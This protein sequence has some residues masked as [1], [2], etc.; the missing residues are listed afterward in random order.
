MGWLDDP[1]VKPTAPAPAGWWEKD[2]LAQAEPRAAEGAVESMQAGLQ[3]SVGGLFW[4][5]KLPDL[6]MD[7]AHAKWWERAL[8]GI[9]QVGADILPMGLGAA[10]GGAAGTAAGTPAGPGGMAVGGVLGAGAGMFGVPALMRE[11]LINGYKSGEINTAADF[12]NALRSGAG[13]IAK[14][15][16]KEALV[17]AA[18]FGAGAVAARTV[19]KALLPAIGESIAVPTAT[20]IIGT[21]DTAAQI[22]TMVTMPAALQGR[23]PDAI[24]FMDAAIVIGGLKAAHP[25]AA[26]ITNVFQRTGRTPAQQ[27]ADAQADPKI[28]EELR[29]GPAADVEVPPLRGQLS[30]Q[31]ELWSIQDRIG[32]I[33]AA[34]DDRPEVRV[35]Y[36]ALK[37]KATALEAEG[38]K[39]EVPRGSL[40]SFAPEQLVEAKDRAAQRIA[41]LTTKEGTGPLTD[42]ERAERIGLVNALNNPEALAKRFGMEPAIKAITDA[43]RQASAER[44]AEEVRRQAKEADMARAVPLGDEHV[45]AITQLVLAR[46]KTR[47]ARLGILPEELYAERPLRIR[48]EA[49]AEIEAE[50]AAIPPEAPRFTPPEV[51]LFGNPIA[52]E[53]APR[54]A[55]A[56][57]A[58]VEV[59]LAGLKLSKEVPQFKKD[60]NAEGVI[61]PLG[62]KFDRTGVGPIQVWERI[63]GSMEVISGRHRLDLARRSGEETIPAQIHREADGFTAKQAA[64][65][66]AQLNIR[67][68]QG[69]G[70][71]FAQYFRDSGISEQTANELGLLARA[72]GRGGFAI[73]RDASPDLLAA[74]RAGLLSDDAALAISSTAPGSARLQ[75]LGIAM[76]NDGKSALYAANM[77]RSI[78]LMAAERMA[79]GAQGDIFGFDDSAM[80][81]A[82]AMAKKASSK[83]R[84]ISEQISA[85]SGASRRPELARKMGVD[86]QDPEGIQKKIAELKQEQYQ[87]DNWPLY[88]ELVAK[89][90]AS[91]TG[92]AKEPQADYTVD[93][94][95]RQ[96]TGRI[97]AGGTE[98]PEGQFDLFAPAPIPNSPVK[99]LE[100]IVVEPEQVGKQAVSF[101]RVRDA[102]EA[103]SI[104]QDLNR[105]PMEKFQVL[106]L[107]EKNKPIAFFDLFAGTVNQTSV[108]PREVWTAIYQTPG[109][110]SVWIAHQHPSGL[111]EPSNADRML[112]KSLRA[113]LTPDIGVTL[114]GHLIITN[115]KTI[116]IG[117]G[118]DEL[119]A[120]TLKAGTSKK[121]IPIMERK[122]VKADDV[123]ES[124]SSPAAV[125]GFLKS[126]SPDDT[127]LLVLDSQ[128]RATGWWPM[129]PAEMATLRTG[130][131]NT[132]MGALIRNVGRGNANSVIAYSPKPTTPEFEKGVRNAGTALKLADV[133]MLDAFTL[134]EQRVLRSHAEAGLPMT[135]L[136]GTFFQSAPRDIFELKPETPAELKA[137][138]EE[139][140]KAAKRKLAQ[141]RAGVKGPVPTVD[142]ADLFNTQRTLFQTAPPVNSEPFKRW[143]GG[144]K[145]TDKDGKPLLVYTGQP[146]DPGPIFLS[147]YK[148]PRLAN[149]P[150][151]SD[152]GF[153]FADQ[154]DVAAAYS[155]TDDS[156]I[157]VVK[158]LYLS[159]QHPLDLRNVG[160]V[161]KLRKSTLEPLQQQLSEFDRVKYSE[162]RKRISRVTGLV[163]PAITSEDLRT[164]FNQP[165]LA[166]EFQ[167]TLDE[168]SAIVTQVEDARGDVKG[169]RRGNYLEQFTPEEFQRILNANGVEF[170]I[171][172]YLEEIKENY[173]SALSGRPTE[174]MP[175]YAFWDFVQSHRLREA[176]KRSGY[177]GII[178][179]EEN[180]ALK[181]K[182]KDVPERADFYPLKGTSYVAFR[183]EQIK[184]A[185]GNRGTF[186]PN[187]PNI[188][189]QSKEDKP[190]Y[191]SELARSVEASPMKQG[192]AKA[193][194]DYIKSRVGK[195]V[196]NEEIDATGINDWLATQEGKVTK[197]QVQAFMEQ[198]GVKVTETMLG[199]SHNPYDA[200]VTKMEEKYGEGYD[201]QALT[202]A[203]R[204][205]QGR[206]WDLTQQRGG[207]TENHTKFQ[208]YQEP[209][210]VPGSYR[211]LVLTLPPVA[212]KAF[213]PNKVTVK[214]N[215]ISTTQG[216]AEIYYDGQKL[217]GPYSDNTGTPSNN[218]MQPESYWIDSARKIWEKGITTP[219]GRQQVAAKSG[220]FSSSH[221]PNAGNYLAH[222]RVND[223]ILP[224]GRKVLFV[225]EIQSDRAQKGRTDGFNSLTPAQVERWKELD[226]MASQE[227]E[228]T[229]TEQAEYDSLDARYGGHGKGGVPAAPFVTKTDSWT[230]L[231][232]KRLLRYAA[233]GEYDAIAWT[234]GEQQVERYTSA[235][236]K[237]V[238]TIEWKKTPEGVQIVGYKNAEKPVRTSR[239]DT[240]AE[241]WAAAHRHESEGRTKVVDTT[242]KESALSDAIGKSMA[243]R[244]R[245]DPNQT[246]TIEGENITVND[247]GMAESY[248]DATGRKGDGTPA[249]ITKV[250]NQILKRMEGGKVSEIKIEMPAQEHD[251]DSIVR[252]VNGRDIADQGQPGFEITPAMREKIMAGQAL[253]QNKGQDRG[254]QHLGSYSIAENLITT[255]RNANKSTV[256]HE[257]SHS[258]LEEMKADAARPDAPAQIKADWEIIRREFAIGADGEISTASHE[259]FARTAERYY[260]E[261]KAPS[262]GLRAVF[263]RFKTWMLEIYAD[264]QN[265]GSEINPEIRGMFD[266]MLATDQEIADA[267]ALDVPRAYVPEARAA[268]AEKIVPPEPER[269]GPQPGFKDEQL[270]IEPFAEELLTGTGSGYT[271][272]SR[273]NA[274]YVDG[275]M[276]L[277]LAIQRVAEIDQQNIQN[278]RGGEG[279]VRSW[280]S[281]NADA[282][283]VAMD[284][285]GI[286][287]DAMG[288]MFT[289][290][291]TI[292]HSILQRAAYKTM[293]S[294]AKYSLQM[295]DTILKKGDNASVQDQYDY[296][297]SI[298]RM[299]MA[300]GELQGLSAET[301]RAMNQ[302]K[303]MRQASVSIDQMVEQIM[304]PARELFQSAKTDAEVAAE[305]KIKLLEIMAQHFSGKSALDIAKLHKDL[306]S[307]KG[308]LK[309]AD[310]VTKA[311]KWEMVV[312]GW[313]AS[314]LSGPVTHTTNLFGTEGFHFLRPAVDALAATIGMARGASPGMGESDRASM[315]E[316]VARITG[317]LGG[318]QDGLKVAAATFRR[319]DPTGKT[320]AYRT[321]IPGRAGEIIRIPLRLMGA[322]DALVSTM[323][324]RGEL[325]TLAIRQAFDEQLNPSTREFAERVQH[326]VDNP[327]PDIQARAEAAATRMTFNAPL[328]EKGVALQLFVNKWN[329][330]WMIPFIR[331][332]IN[333]A[334][335]LLRM[336]PFAPAVGEWRAD[337]AKGGVARDR[338]LA[339]IAL[340]TG[341]TAIT[342][343]YAFAG[344]ISGAGSPDP[345]KN[346]GKEGV[347][348]PY[349]ILI[350]DT[351]YEYARI[352]PTGTLMGMAAD[353]AN[354]WDHMTEEEKDKVPKMLAAAFAQAITNQTF[355][356]GI[357]NAVRAM[358]EPERFL[359]RF[360]QQFAASAVPNI[361]GQ[362]TTMADPVVREVNGM[363]EA[364]QARIPGMRQDLLPKRD[365]LGA[366]VET[367]ERV[368]VVLPSR[369]LKVS[370]DKVRLEAARLDMS[371]AAAPKKTHIGKGTGKLGDVKLTPE[372]IDTFEKVGGE[373]AHKILTNIVNAEGYDAIP[374]LVK[375]KIFSKVLTASH[376]VAA[377][378]ALPMDKRIAYIQSISEKVAQELAPEGAQ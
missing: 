147:N 126:F 100:K 127:G 362:P 31:E 358:S 40:P 213:D 19:G 363:I 328:G 332:P 47:A 232:L 192:T 106:G 86:V 228:L 66:D 11:L 296:L 180:L 252:T 42:V 161:L 360:L 318:V 320:E 175:P 377:V 349:S 351:W 124:L 125:R 206:L 361:I 264:L 137:R 205:E 254:D 255:F 293:V 112:T 194:Q 1:E 245:N 82:A 335:E 226:H 46:V 297:Y 299:R 133:N 80:R 326:L 246:G 265:I 222:T 273:V 311:T 202:P 225:E 279:G 116:D 104:F 182:F 312:E 49:Q 276:Q 321:A 221:F 215:R 38:I 242:E 329:L 170:D 88:P 119:S 22:A 79:A 240:A 156:G 59:P 154:K 315:S 285:L 359:P 243:D 176:I 210:A 337:I 56:D 20:K 290:E 191:Y 109:I 29:N 128:N 324:M 18:T 7:P 195:G 306:G 271:N 275:P 323:Y 259:Q 123:R 193:W 159:I 30:K 71:D 292:P 346:R 111:A 186:D 227:R 26:R 208:D 21:A 258:W 189:Y 373:M 158:T 153:I 50:Q 117:S 101:N 95:V 303:D 223:R 375:R 201:T 249:I 166:D 268:E 34:G 322:E 53:T 305:T 164:R 294:I 85:V 368:G 307:L 152:I 25:I 301:G 302:M 60:A 214:R 331:T 269:K 364:I 372:E 314:L 15:T 171:K 344:N 239:G 187:N 287:P 83:Q 136:G 257:L 33:E 146:Q 327:T 334:K 114:R 203:E 150:V 341:I 234:R 72:K 348:Q 132:G 135:N 69:S 256:V 339:E 217:A 61:V 12:W 174:R 233:E 13:E 241:R 263:E 32:M 142:Q 134:D 212:D 97:E 200:F 272:D 211:E 369:T 248:G 291:T 236:R 366:P 4:R 278:K 143:F 62:G 68:E 196:K 229:A 216:T 219:D 338:A 89:L 130:D 43:E 178:F 139:A 309:F 188:L 260:G 5:G 87:W 120:V 355:L 316:A 76:V 172:P 370:E 310:T 65:L 179:D 289:G 51:D 37:A 157:G 207:M 298:M 3:A 140:A 16:G 75:A 122:I 209:G 70:A 17:G 261:G 185:I 8:T 325:K 155:T 336:S 93:H 304:P 277:K 165:D 24:E 163:N 99:T 148:N 288:R 52:P 10:F 376:Q 244:I 218:W 48:D 141:E 204:T 102:G 9:S 231:V 41:E 267:R 151:K 224:D 115:S 81:E 39:A 350:G 90:R 94:E 28:A 295:R 55:V 183:P 149:K 237:A 270:A 313:K 247:T 27:V 96:E 63:D 105:S 356:Q 168:R 266:R 365:W 190:W 317:M 145:V 144:S 238:D 181:S 342:M 378:A 230:A 184:S 198:G 36:D 78:D 371:M 162:I 138:D 131:A 45:D 235:L 14:G 77:M 352:Q 129:T 74:Y 113:V 92:E 199:E 283:K 173:H 23:L 281:A 35:E 103:A 177:D 343:A 367:K 253:F 330:Q 262:V 2:P 84:A 57:L 118:G 345:G 282:D 284:A 91:E 347:W 286:G 197:E 340:G 121:T 64:T 354:I 251:P 274:Q 54:A 107:D 357:T 353:I 110:K 58:T 220:G 167:R 319:D 308:N 374:D 73:A 300:Q 67:E 108:Y 160:E 280:D 169:G 6:V 250:A 44:V 98:T 333:I